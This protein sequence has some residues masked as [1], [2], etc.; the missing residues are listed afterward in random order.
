MVSN[1][2]PHALMQSP[3]NPILPSTKKRRISWTRLY[4]AAQA[5]AITAASHKHTGPILVVV[6][7]TLTGIR[8]SEEVIFFDPKITVL[9]F[10]DWET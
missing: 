10:P 1:K 8:L 2:N 5:L 3:F 7:D 4:A 6:P 9:K